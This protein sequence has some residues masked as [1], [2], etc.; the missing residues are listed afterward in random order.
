MDVTAGSAAA[1]SSLA[2]S[3]PAKADPGKER[4]N[5]GEF[6][7]HARR[8]FDAYDAQLWQTSSAFESVSRRFLR[9]LAVDLSGGF[10]FFW[11]LGVLNTR[12]LGSQE[13]DAKRASID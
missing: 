6:Y 1:L 5:H 3:F 13:R 7:R 9:A 2:L 8:V 12:A 4:G 10:S 11:I